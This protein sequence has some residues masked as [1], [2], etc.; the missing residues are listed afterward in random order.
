M[1]NP[2]YEE[3]DGP[4]LAFL[5]RLL[6]QPSCR[7]WCLH[8]DNYALAA[9]WYQC[10]S[11]CAEMID[12]RV[13]SGQRRQG[14]GTRLLRASF[15]ALDSVGRVNLEVRAGN[16]PARALYDGMGFKIV[17]RRA[18]YYPTTQGREDAL[19]MSLLLRG[20]R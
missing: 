1:L 7:A 13:R 19:L 10:D 5:T 11:D 6:A 3:V 14:L 4:G 17:G 18:D 12:L 2:L 16:A 20:T 15:G 8:R 9:V